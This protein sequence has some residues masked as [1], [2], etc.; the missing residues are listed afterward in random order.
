[1]T[2]Q[3]LL[4]LSNIVVVVGLVLAALGGFGNF[5]FQGQIDQQQIQVEEQRAA[6]IENKE[7]E[8]Q[9]AL[10]EQQKLKD[11]EKLVEAEQIRRRKILSKL[12]KQYI[13]SHDGISSEFIVGKA[14]IPKDWVEQQ[15]QEQGETWQQNEYY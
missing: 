15:L 4:T 3:F 11:A 5:Y 8:A 14:P 7:K 9:R 12:R 2:N 1:M 6:A 10:A 13:L